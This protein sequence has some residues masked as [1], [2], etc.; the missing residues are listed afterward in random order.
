MVARIAR[1]PQPPVFGC[2]EQ[3]IYVPEVRDERYGTGRVLTCVFHSM[4]KK[5]ASS[6]GGGSS[7]MRTGVPVTAEQGNRLGLELN[8][9]HYLSLKDRI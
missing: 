6:P 9:Y 1:I 8:T 5:Q 7:A 4:K 2:V 3:A